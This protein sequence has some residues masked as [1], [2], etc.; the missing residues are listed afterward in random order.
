M[1]SLPCGA[2]TLACWVEIRLDPHFLW[3]E[4]ADKSVGAAD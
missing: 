3:P 2:G 4:G 1:V